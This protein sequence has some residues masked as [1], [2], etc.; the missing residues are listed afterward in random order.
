VL[1]VGHPASETLSTARADGSGFSAGFL[2]CHVP[3]FHGMA[4]SRGGAKLAAIVAFVEKHD[5]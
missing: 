2:I 3:S 5:P 4:L 1:S